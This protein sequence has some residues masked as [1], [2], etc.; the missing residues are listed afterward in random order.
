MRQRVGHLV[1]TNPPL[2]VVLGIGLWVL[3][4]TTVAVVAE[5]LS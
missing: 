3:A 2:L 1:N 4:L 5:K